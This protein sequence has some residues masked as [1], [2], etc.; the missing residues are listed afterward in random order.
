M[1]STHA[2]STDDGTLYYEVRGQGPLL[3]LTAAPMTADM[4]APLADA[5]AD[6]HTVVTHDPRG[7]GRSALDD[8]EQDS[9]PALRAD[10]LAALLADLGA[11]DA[12]FVGSSGGAVTT[13]ALAERHPEL[14]RTIVAHEPPL[15][16]LLPD[17]EQQF[18]ATEEIIATYHRDGA[19]AAWRR[20]MINAGF[21]LPE[22]GTEAFD[23]SP[24]GSE[25]GPNDRRFYVHELRGTVHHRVDPE[26]IAA[27]RA[28]V[29]PGVGADSGH[30]ATDRT[31]RALAE[32]LGTAPVVFPGDHGGFME[33]PAGFA[34]VVREVLDPVTGSGPRPTP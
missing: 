1:T 15:M 7:I 13:L 26:R 29:V 28:R 9:T 24:A 14:A 3:V 27:G 23:A 30:L 31:T 33:D 22:E 16:G 8:P 18:A 6:D 20:F 5:L 12:D 4:F 34:A 32:L 19:G 17:A 10:D 21:P 25:G 11:A 2:L